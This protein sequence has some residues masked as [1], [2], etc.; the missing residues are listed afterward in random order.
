MFHCCKAS[1]AG[2][3]P[4]QKKWRSFKPL[5]GDVF[6]RKVIKNGRCI[7]HLLLRLESFLIGTVTRGTLR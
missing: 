3:P 2:D 5:G 7:P 4:E 1:A 6:S